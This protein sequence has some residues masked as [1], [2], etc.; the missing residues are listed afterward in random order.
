MKINDRGQLTQ[1]WFFD[2]KT[3]YFANS[4]RVVISATIHTVPVRNTSIGKKVEINDRV[5]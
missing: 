4:E 3:C 1:T 2:N 5:K